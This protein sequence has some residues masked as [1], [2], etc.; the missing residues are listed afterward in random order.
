MYFKKR[1]YKKAE[2]DMLVYIIIVLLI[3]VLIAMSM[4]IYI[5][6]LVKNKRFEKEFL[7]RDISLL[8]TTAYSSPNNIIISYSY[9]GPL[10]NKK[11]VAK[12]VSGYLQLSKEFNFNYRFAPNLLEVYEP[13]ND[14]EM[15]KARFYYIEDKAILFP[16]KT[17]GI[18]K[19]L[20]VKDNDQ[21]LVSENE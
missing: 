5:D 4:W 6:N 10:V 1:L 16:E 14:D 20:F 11:E 18:N 17:I 12:D 3:V 7:A 21:F 2:T 9:K 8:A 15:N 13:G 19:M